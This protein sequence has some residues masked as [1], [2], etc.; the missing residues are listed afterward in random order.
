VGK[1]GTTDL[2]GGTRIKMLFPNANRETPIAKCQLATG[3]LRNKKIRVAPGKSMVN[4]STS[5]QGQRTD[6]F[7]A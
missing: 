7:H 4:K 3:N 2:R 6:H 5:D 1:T